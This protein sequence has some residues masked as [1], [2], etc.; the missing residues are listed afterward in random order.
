MPPITNTNKDS[1]GQVP[2]K[3]SNLV[4]QEVGS[5][6]GPISGR[7]RHCKKMARMKREAS[8]SPGRIPAIKSFPMDSSVSIPK[9]MNPMLGGIRMPRVP[10]A[11]TQP[12]ARLRSYPYF[13]ISGTATLAMVAPVA[14]EDPQ[15]AANPEQATMVA[16]ASPPLKWPIQL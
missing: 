16:M 2:Y 3:D 11:A 7:K 9:I 8:R 14:R 15:M 6:L 10:P 1:M 13:L 12:V 5:A 4:F